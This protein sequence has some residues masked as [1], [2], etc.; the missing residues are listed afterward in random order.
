MGFTYFLPEPS[1]QQYVENIIVADLN[2]SN[3]FSK[4]ITIVPDYRSCLCFVLEDKISAFEQG[5]LLERERV[6]FTGFHLF[7][8]IMNLGR[9]HHAVCIQFKPIGWNRLMNHLPQNEM[10]NN[11]FDARLFL[12]ND[13]D[14]LTERLAEANKAELQNQIIQAFLK[15]RL[16][17]SE[18]QIP[19]DRAIQAFI[20]SGGK[21][22]VEKAASQ[23]CLSTRQFERLCNQKIGVSPR[24]FGRLIR[25]SNAYKLKEKHP[26]LSWSKIAFHCGYFD[27]MHLIRDF[28]QFSGTTPGATEE[29]D[30]F[31]SFPYDRNQHTSP[32]NLTQR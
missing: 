28:K 1:L 19:F 9:K 26:H 29:E 27:H 14:T 2:F 11:C 32:I 7:P 25:F 30:H 4:E 8:T 21:L 20:Q 6:I 24:M 12:G 22:S 16:G 5:Q 31:H 17:K 13:A 15:E 23:A 10:L 18:M 3:D